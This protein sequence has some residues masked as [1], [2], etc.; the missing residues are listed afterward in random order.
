MS[1]EDLEKELYGQRPTRP[2]SSQNQKSENAQEERVAQNK[3]TFDP[4]GTEQK[5]QTRFSQRLDSTR[6]SVAVA[7]KT[8]GVGKALIWTGVVSLVVLIGF[9]GY[10]LYQYFTT[11]DVL[12]TVTVPNTV[13]VGQLFSANVSFENVSSKKLIA[14]KMSLSLPDGLVFT[15]NSDKRVLESDVHDVNPQETIQMEYQ[16]LAT[17]NPQQTYDI[18]AL[19]SYGY[20]SASFSSRFEKNAIAHVVIQD[21]VLGLAVSA[22][23]KTLNGEEIDITT[24]YQN[25]SNQAIASTTLVFTFPKG[26]VVTGS[27]VPLDS[28]NTVEIG[29]IPAHQEGTVVVSGYMVGDEY[30]YFTTMLDAYTRIGKVSVPLIHKTISTSILPSP[31]TISVARDGAITKPDV[32][33]AGDKLSYKITCENTGDT[34]LSELVAQVVFDGDSFDT[35]SIGGSGFFNSTKKAYVWT[36]AQVA[37][38]AELAPH[39]SLTIPFTIALKK[40]VTAAVLQDGLLRVR[41]QAVSP[42][43][44]P[45]IAAKETIGIGQAESRIGGILGF[46]QSVYYTEPTTDIQ[47][48]GPFPAQVGKETQYTV[49]WNFSGLGDFNNTIVSATLAPGVSWTGKVKVLGTDATPVYNNRTQQITWTIPAIT[50]TEMAK[51]PPQLVFQI[52]FTPSEQYSNNTFNIASSAQLQS[53]E[54][55]SQKQITLSTQSLMSRNFSGTGLPEGYYRVLP[56]EQ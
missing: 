7:K 2:R 55:L 9:A 19:V 44:S 35:A 16:L 14:P 3:S 5:Q 21:T 42:T 22:P 27:N 37:G 33:Y 4:W 1:L 54:A 12:I 24:Q 50:T 28:N 11:K 51:Q 31:L 10:Y 25:T 8:G 17:G 39:S 20:E 26:F 45:T 43:V 52:S 56:A 53:V 48:T 13:L 29:T 46:T 40:T 6:S 41:A 34:P 18:Q 47:N 49:H 23:E 30:S 32:V 15:D 38:L 36:A